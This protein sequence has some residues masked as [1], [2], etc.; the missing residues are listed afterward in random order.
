M[1]QGYTAAY[2]R[3]APQAGTERGWMALI[4]LIWL[5]VP[6]A[7][8]YMIKDDKLGYEEELS[9]Q[10]LF[11]EERSR[12]L[13]NYTDLYQVAAATVLSIDTETELQMWQIEWDSIV[14]MEQEDFLRLSNARMSHYPHTTAKLQDLQ[15]LLDEQRNATEEG[16]R[17]REQYI[18][19]AHSLES[20]AERID[21][22]RATAEYYRRLGAQAIYMLIME[23]LA[24]LEARYKDHRT[25]R[26]DLMSDSQ[27]QLLLSDS[28]SMEIR[29]EIS[30][31][32]RV[33]SQDTETSY[34][35]ML[36]ERFHDFDLRT[37]L[38]TLITG[39][40]AVAATP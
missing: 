31:L 30:H 3:S 4:M 14:A 32:D 19:S 28:L 9:Q 17:L 25:S 22:A 39:R 8:F 10:V 16:A 2:S 15:I 35:E 6:I 13:E 20:I 11:C 36:V 21:R 27:E 23:D 12:H 40:P 33:I 5:C 34:A 1:Y 26:M 29:R 37:E 7:A 38:D 24:V 18:N